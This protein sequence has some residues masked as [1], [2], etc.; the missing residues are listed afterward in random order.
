M[1]L[2]KKLSPGDG[3]VIFDFSIFCQMLLWFFVKQNWIFE[4]F[5]FNKK[6]IKIDN[7]SK[8]ESTKQIEFEY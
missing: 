1:L 6:S 8:P 3:F 4:I 2:D 5:M 7:K